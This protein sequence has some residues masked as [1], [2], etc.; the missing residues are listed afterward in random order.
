MHAKT[1][2]R[3]MNECMLKF[4]ILAQILSKYTC[5]CTFIGGT[6]TVL[7]FISINVVFN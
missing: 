7:V 5:T 1:Q 3:N 4:L 2:T 6:T